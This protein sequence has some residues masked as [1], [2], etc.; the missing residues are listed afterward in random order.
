MIF[1]SEKVDF[2]E[3]KSALDNCIYLEDSSVTI[4]GIK[5]YGSPH[6]PPFHDWGF[7]REEEEIKE[8][9]SGIPGDT[10]ILITHGPPHDI[11]DMCYSG[12]KAGCKHLKREIFERVK[13]KHHIFG[14]IHEASGR[15]EQAGIDFINASSCNLRYKPVHQAYVFD[16]EVK[17][18]N[19]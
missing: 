9:W 17:D 18:E 4:G 13:P 11:L 6:Q 7:N 19:S 10:D 15:L 2:S 5:I 16:M 1:L 12:V 14:H 8:L 3:C